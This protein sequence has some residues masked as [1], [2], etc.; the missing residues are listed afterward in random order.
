MTDQDLIGLVK[1][2][3]ALAVTNLLAIKPALASS[4]DE[5]GVSALMISIYWGKAE[6]TQI[7]RKALPALTF[8]EACALGDLA[9]MDA[10]AQANPSVVNQH[11]ADGF[12]G[13]GFA[14]FFG[15]TAIA[16]R[17]LQLGANVDTPSSNGLAVTPLG[18]A[19]AGKHIELAKLLLAHGANPNHQ[20]NGGFAPLHSACQNDDL[21]M[22]KLLLQAGANPLTKTDEGKT[23]ADHCTGEHTEQIRA[24]LAG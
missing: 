20:Q 6:I 22:V 11:A 23:P 13:L 7:I 24:L 17:L 12:G 8:Y 14:A 4:T 5:N 3:D 16:Q 15:H 21:A 19:A 9:A 18:S 1:A 2:G 10:A